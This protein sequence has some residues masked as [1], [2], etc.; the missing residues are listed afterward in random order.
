MQVCPVTKTREIKRVMYF[1]ATDER[2]FWFNTHCLNYNNTA[3]YK[4]M[5]GNGHRINTLD[6]TTRLF[7]C[8]VRNVGK[9][10]DYMV[11]HPTRWY[12]WPVAIWGS[13]FVKKLTVVQ[14][15]N[16]FTGHR[17]AYHLTVSWSNRIQT[18]FSNIFPLRSISV[19]SSHLCLDLSSCVFHLSSITTSF[20][21]SVLYPHT[22]YELRLKSS[23]NASPQRHFTSI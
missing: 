10:Q 14:L 20:F 9:L 13:D 7:G 15:T 12:Y 16:Q 1:V 18:L 6:E 2:C 23:R 3:T 17:K 21:A 5:L 19:L 8:F 4:P 11:S 22:S